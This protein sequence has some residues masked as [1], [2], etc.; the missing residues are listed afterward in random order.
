MND[1]VRAAFPGEDG[2]RRVGEWMESIVL[3]ALAPEG[4][5]FREADLRASG[6]ASSD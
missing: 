5:Q 2:A 3:G 6:P 1:M 4:E